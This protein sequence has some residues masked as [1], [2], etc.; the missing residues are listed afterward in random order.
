MGT[1]IIDCFHDRA[2]FQICW[3]HRLAVVQW[4]L[5]N[6]SI[7]PQINSIAQW[8]YTARWKVHYSFYHVA[9]G[10]DVI[11]KGKKSRGEKLSGCNVAD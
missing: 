1:V 4:I 11:L 5:V 8:Q 7:D 2:L 9:Q 6:I 10:N 3:P